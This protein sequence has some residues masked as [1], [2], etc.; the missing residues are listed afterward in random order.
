M[1]DIQL[2]SGSGPS[3]I[4]VFGSAIIRVAPDIASLKFGVSRLEQK[5]RDAFNAARKGS[6]NVQ[7]YLSK[8]NINDFGSSRI[9][10]SQSFRYINGESKFM[11]YQARVEF[12][13]LLHDLDKLEEVLTSVVDAGANEITST[14]LQTTRLK[15]LRAEARQKA[16]IAAR[17]KAENYCQAAGVK[18]GEVRYILDINPDELRGREGHVVREPMPDEDV[19]VKA[20]DPGSIVVGGAV[21]ITFGLVTI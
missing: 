8:A 13:V 14:D 12:H 16:V 3:G 20:F 11:G 5:P 9:M 7:E 19:L 17:E 6:K 1:A 18:L 10:L 15:Q 4:N 2:L 21:K